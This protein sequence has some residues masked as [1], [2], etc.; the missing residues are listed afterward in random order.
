MSPGERAAIIGAIIA[1][2]FLVGMLTADWCWYGY[3]GP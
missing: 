3:C 2:A 1:T